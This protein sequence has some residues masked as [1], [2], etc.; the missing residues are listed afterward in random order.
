MNYYIREI[1][2]SDGLQRTAGIKARDDIELIFKSLNITPIDIPCNQK[3][4]QS[5]TNF[6]HLLYHKKIYKI[7]KN[8]LS[9]LNSNDIVFIQFPIIEHSIF[10]S[11]LFKELKKKS[12]KVVLIIHDLELLRYAKRKDISK[13][14]KIRLYLEEKNVL[15]LCHRLILHNN[16]M[17]EYVYKLGIEKSKILNLEIFDYI[18]N[19]LDYSKMSENRLGKNLPVIIAG[20]LRPHKAQYAYDLPENIHFNLYGVDYSGDLK[21]NI[22]YFGSFPPNELPYV[23]EG[24]FGLVWDG[25]SSN[26]CTG[27][28]GEYLKINNPHKTSLYLSLGIPIIIWSQAALADFIKENNCGIVVDS[29]YDIKSTIEKLTDDEYDVLLV[30]AKKVSKK[31]MNGYYTKKVIKQII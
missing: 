4:R 21:E 29:L 25:I 3:N 23:L 1:N 17:V 12:I 11:K 9:I 26:T 2:E 19:D 10:L 6:N 8:Q 28:Y 15:K 16:R 5:G 30:N 24:S 7:W 22:H 27:V 31:L 18:I 20:N 13:K 14:K